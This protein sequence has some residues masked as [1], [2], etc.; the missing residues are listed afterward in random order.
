MNTVVDRPARE[1]R[2][3]RGP[4]AETPPSSRD[5]PASTA[6]DAAPESPGRIR[7]PLWLMAG[8]M[9][10][11]FGIVAAVMTQG[12][13]PVQVPSP[14]PTIAVAAPPKQGPD[15]HTLLTAAQ[16]DGDWLL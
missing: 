1:K 14:A 7:N 3:T 12:T 16:D 4:D 13:E 2:S 8:G 15:A 5:A 10:C 9:A 6:L 11:F